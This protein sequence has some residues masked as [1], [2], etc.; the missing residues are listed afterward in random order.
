MKEFKLNSATKIQ[1]GFKAPEG[2][3]DTFA[4][5][6]IQ[7]VPEEETVIS[8]FQKRKIVMLIAAVLSYYN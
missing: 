7:K 3:F 2:Y 6:V 1:S 5:N 4:Q 8:I